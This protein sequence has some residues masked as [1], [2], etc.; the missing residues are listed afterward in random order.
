[1]YDV[2]RPRALDDPIDDLSKLNCMLYDKNNL[3]LERSKHNK[4]IWMY[5]ISVKVYK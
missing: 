1:M 4:E 2:E 3:F 5:D